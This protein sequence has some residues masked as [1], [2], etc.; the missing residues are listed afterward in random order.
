LQFVNGRILASPYKEELLAFYKKI[1]RQEQIQNDERDPVQSELKL[2]GLL[3]PAPASHLEIRN[4][5]YRQVFDQEWIKQHQPP[6]WKRYVWAAL[7]LVTILSVGLSL[8]FYQ[9]AQNSDERLAETY[10]TNFTSTENSTLRLDNLANLI[11]LGGYEEEALALFQELSP[12]DRFL[13]FQVATPDLQPQIE[14]VIETTYTTQWDESL[15]TENTQHTDLTLLMM[16]SAIQK[17]DQPT[18]PDLESELSSWIYA[19]KDYQDGDLEN[20]QMHYSNAID[21]NSDN[22][23]T[24]YERALVSSEL[25]D[26]ELLL[27]DLSAL[28]THGQEWESRVRSIFFRNPRL[29]LLLDAEENPYHNLEQFVPATIPYEW[30]TLAAPTETPT[31]TETAVPSPT[32]TATQAPPTPTATPELPTPT[33]VVATPTPTPEPV[34]ALIETSL[35]IRYTVPTGSIVYSCKESGRSSE[36]CSINADGSN[37]QQLNFEGDINWMASFTAGLTNILFSSAISGNST[38]FEADPDGQNAH[39]ISTQILDDY[40][41]AASPDNELIAFTRDGGGSRNIWVMNRDGTDAHPLTSIIGKAVS[42]SWSPDGTQI[43][44]SQ[45]L[46]GETFYSLF[47]MNAD[48]TGQRKLPIPLLGIGDWVDWSPTGQWLAFYA[49]FPDT[50]E[51][52]IVTADGDLY[53]QVTDGGA[54]LEPSFSPD[55]NWLVF[56]SGRYS[57]ANL[58]LIRLNGT[59]LTPLTDDDDITNTQPRWGR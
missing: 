37:Q 44:Y 41:P 40:W 24:H 17:F 36:V 50:Y 11:A 29:Y 54:S 56:T 32:P 13:L 34:T 18:N 53:Y 58:Y 35:A 51:A 28:Q 45:R 33:V 21:L 55:G 16:L 39:P 12:V 26:D 52:Y 4:K 31:P 48:G 49:G 47:I 10:I 2:Y 38:I 23:G 42:P 15:T 3:K 25:G 5:I 19:K 20:A 7:I 22:P 1:H 6:V 27:A 30:I 57:D 9:Q 8:Y 46:D 59:L 14:S 43:A